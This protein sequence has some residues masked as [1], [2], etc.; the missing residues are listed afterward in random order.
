MDHSN[1][2]KRYTIEQLD[3]TLPI[4]GGIRQQRIIGIGGERAYAYRARQDN[5][6]IPARRARFIA[7]LMDL[8]EFQ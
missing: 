3:D 8:R 5:F 2:H 7:Y 6:S 1:G 4:A